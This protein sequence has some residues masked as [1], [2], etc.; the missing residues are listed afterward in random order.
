VCLQLYFENSLL[1][2]QQPEPPRQHLS[3][4]SSPFVDDHSDRYLYTDRGEAHL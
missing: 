4:N 1:R 2:V 3:L